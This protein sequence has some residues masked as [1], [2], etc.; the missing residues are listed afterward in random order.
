MKVRSK[1]PN[2]VINLDGFVTAIIRLD[3]FMGDKAEHI[4]ETEYWIDN[5][6]DSGDEFTTRMLVH[7]RNELEKAE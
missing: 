2:S 4:K 3:M 1:N 7:L 6:S 5:T